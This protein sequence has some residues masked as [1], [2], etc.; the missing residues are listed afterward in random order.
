MVIMKCCGVMENA[1]P[2]GRISQRTESQDPLSPLPIP[3]GERPATLL[4]I[5]DSAPPPG[6]EG[7]TK[8][9]GA[10]REESKSYHL[11][12]HTIVDEQA[13]AYKKIVAKINN[14]AGDAT[15]GVTGST[16][17]SS[18]TSGGKGAIT[19][20]AVWMQKKAIFMKKLLLSASL[21]KPKLR[22]L[23]FKKKNAGDQDGSSEDS[24]QRVLFIG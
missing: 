18:F 10:E 2:R 8:S 5:L 16:S 21:K 4:T 7:V 3:E 22:S 17:L 6:K 11:Q 13:D 24:S 1:L 14:E 12:D 20:Q 9:G 23:G 15:P 19:A